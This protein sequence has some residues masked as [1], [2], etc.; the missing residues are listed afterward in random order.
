MNQGF[1]RKANVMVNPAKTFVV[2]TKHG[3]KLDGTFEDDAFDLF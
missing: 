1:M 2:S 3:V